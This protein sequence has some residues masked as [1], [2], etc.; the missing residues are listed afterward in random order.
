MKT[1]EKI[2]QTIVRKAQADLENQLELFR[3]NENPWAE[4]I[5]AK[6]LTCKEELCSDILFMFFKA[7]C[8]LL[9]HM[10]TKQR[11]ANQYAEPLLMC[12]NHYFSPNFTGVIGLFYNKKYSKYQIHKSKSL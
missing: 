11:S 9:T 3:K 10:N 4:V 12:V 2:V 6:V 5:S 7:G 1:T 8:A